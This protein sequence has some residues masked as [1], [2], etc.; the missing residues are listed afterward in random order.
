MSGRSS[1]WFIPYD[2][3][4]GKQIERRLVLHTV[5]LASA[6]GIDVRSLPL[7]GMAG[8]RFI[9]FLLANR[10]LG[11]TKFTSIE[12]D[13][14]ILDRCKFNKPFAKMEVYD[15][16][17]SQFVTER[18]FR[19]PA[20]IWFDYEAGVNADLREE[21]SALASEVRPGTFVFIT[22]TAELPQRF[23]KV[24]RLEDRLTVLCEELT[25]LGVDATA[26]QM[27][28]QEFIKVSPQIFMSALMSGFSRR[29]DGV[30]SPYFRLC[31]K[32]ST[33]MLT[34]GG[35]FGEPGTVVKFE[36]ILREQC[37]FLKPNDPGF[38]FYVEQFNLT[39]AERRLLDRATI[40]PRRNSKERRKA[41]AIGVRES[42]IEQYADLMRF[43]PRYFESLI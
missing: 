4:P 24:K 3:R 27:T 43:I 29:A 20:I 40:A 31:Y 13:K 2:I 8:F 32:D 19:T 14:D 25:P 41:R 5:Q 35:F 23:G 21:M 30:F 9:D 6:I 36:T 34:V 7:F 12:H 18:G 33:W 16:T 38:V 15:G 42:V 26:D 37:A 1:A 39:D 17:A 11:T 28:V 22:A 10:V